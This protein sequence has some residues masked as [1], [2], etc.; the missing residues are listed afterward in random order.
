MWVEG[1]LRGIIPGLYNNVESP[2][3]EFKSLN[4][5]FICTKAA[6]KWLQF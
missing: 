5:L 3:A 4:L 6:M 1:W 2:T